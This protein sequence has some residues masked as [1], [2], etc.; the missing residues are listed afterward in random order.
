MAVAPITPE[1][2]TLEEARNYLGE[3]QIDPDVAGNLQ[4]V[5]NSVT[6]WVHAYLRRRHLVNDGTTITEYVRGRGDNELQ[7]KEYPLVEVSEVVTWPFH[8][9][10]GYTITGPGATQYDD[11]MYYD[12]LTGQVWLK[13]YD[14]PDQPN[15]AKVTYKAGYDSGSVEL[16]TIKGATLELIQFH[17]GRHVNNDAGI[18]SKTQGDDSVTYTLRDID[19][20]VIRQLHEFRRE[21]SA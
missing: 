19:P 21:W 8:D 13:N 12:R 2:V 14:V 3:Q 6:G 20:A 1:I 4:T 9:T 7:L 16:A 17:W 18:E 10:L 11:E 15:G 5:I